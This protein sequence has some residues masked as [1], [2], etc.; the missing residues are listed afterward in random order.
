MSNATGKNIGDKLFRSFIAEILA[1]WYKTD[2]WR[3]YLSGPGDTIP[4]WKKNMGDTFSIRK[5]K[6]GTDEFWRLID[7]W[8]PCVCS[9]DCSPEYQEDKKDKK[10]DTLLYPDWWGGHAITFMKVDGKYMFIDSTRSNDTYEVTKDYINN[11]N[12]F[13]SNTVLFFIKKPWLRISS[14]KKND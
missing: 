6:R 8:I 9:I 5:E 10:L 13:W 1:K 2:S 12:L 11:T 3:S 14:S 4:R 7:K